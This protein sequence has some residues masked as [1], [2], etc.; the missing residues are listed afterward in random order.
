MSKLSGKS[1]WYKN[2]QKLNITNWKWEYLLYEQFMH[3]NVL[4]KSNKIIHAEVA[5]DPSR[6]GMSILFSVGYLIIIKYLKIW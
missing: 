2:K 3:T 1:K 5:L 4:Y 6:P